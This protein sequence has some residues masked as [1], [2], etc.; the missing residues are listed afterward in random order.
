MIV[1]NNEVAH[2]EVC[3]FLGIP[4]Y[5]ESIQVPDG[6]RTYRLPI[7]DPK[8]RDWYEEVQLNQFAIFGPELSLFVYCGYGKISKKIVYWVSQI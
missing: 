1:A 2:Q 4:Y 3:R 7:Y 8:R 6:A 5:T